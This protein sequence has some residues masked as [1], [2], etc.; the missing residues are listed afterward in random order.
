VSS[1]NKFAQ[2]ESAGCYTILAATK[3][4]LFVASGF[5][6]SLLEEKHVV[7]CAEWIDEFHFPHIPSFELVV[8]DEIFSNIL[9]CSTLVS[10]PGP[11]LTSTD[12][13]EKKY[14]PYH[15]P[16]HKK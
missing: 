11:D 9:G 2:C 10:E 14:V 8:T 5:K 4:F 12:Q 16:H 7:N 6:T 15:H 13:P 3:E 1:N